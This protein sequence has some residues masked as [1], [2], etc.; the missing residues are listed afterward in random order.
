[1]SGKTLVKFIPVSPHRGQLVDV[2][3]SAPDIDEVILRPT[4]NAEAVATALREGSK[5]MAS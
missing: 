1:M 2:V 3:V 5:W 4:N